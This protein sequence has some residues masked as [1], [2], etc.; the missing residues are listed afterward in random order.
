MVASMG[1]L[2]LMAG[3]KGRRVV[4]P[5]TLLLSHRFWGMNVGNHSQLIA[6]RRRE[7][8]EH[9]RIV[10]HYLQHSNIKSEQVLEEKLLRDVDAWLTPEEG[11]EF[12]LVDVID[13]P[14]HSV[15][16]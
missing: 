13:R 11:V 2:I 8:L 12:G 10:Q 1:L 3:Y 6:G 5:R 16:R 15:G 4:T 14:S 7:D 9:S